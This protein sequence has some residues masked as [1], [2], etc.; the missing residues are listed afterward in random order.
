MRYKGMQYKLKPGSSFLLIT[1]Y[2]YI[3]IDHWNT[4]KNTRDN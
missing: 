1:N 3:S 2:R 4:I